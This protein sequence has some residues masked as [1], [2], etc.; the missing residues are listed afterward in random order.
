MATLSIDIISRSNEALLRKEEILLALNS[1][2]AESQQE[3][4]SF[5]IGTLPAGGQFVN[6]S[7]VDGAAIPY[8]YN[9]SIN[10]QYFVTTLKASPYYTDFQDPEIT[11]QS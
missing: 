5:F 3:L 2:Y 8:R 11:T 10:I 4:N 1:Q 6:L 9:I 7:Y